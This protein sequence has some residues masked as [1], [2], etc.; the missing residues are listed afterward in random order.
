[1]KKS[2]FF[3]A[4]EHICF[5]EQLSWIHHIVSFYLLP[6]TNSQIQQKK[7]GREKTPRG[8]KEDEDIQNERQRQG[9]EQRDRDRNRGKIE[10]LKDIFKF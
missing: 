6:K 1:M 10:F 7:N 9:Q 8:K 2:E 5:Q 3:R 4:F